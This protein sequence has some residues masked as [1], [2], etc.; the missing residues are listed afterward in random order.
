[1]TRRKTVA[2]IVS[3]L[4]GLGGVAAAHEGH[5]HGK[6]HKMIG[7]V[8]AVHA[9]LNHVEITTN[10]GKKDGFYVNDQTKFLKGKATMALSDLTP[11]TR[12]VIDAKM[13]GGKMIATRVRIGSTAQAAKSG[14][15]PHD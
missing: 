15:H 12:V 3:V 7:T 13:E 4:V 8:K 9:N 11:G 5:S 2:L 14:S 6:T 1:M 10:K